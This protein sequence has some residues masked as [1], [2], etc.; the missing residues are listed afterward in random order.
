[1]ILLL[2]LLKE[3]AQELG[4]STRTKDYPKAPNIMSREINNLREAFE[5]IGVKIEFIK[6]TIREWHIINTNYKDPM[7]EAFLESDE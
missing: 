1:M 3:Q 7:N 2:K 5:K 6:G 4:V